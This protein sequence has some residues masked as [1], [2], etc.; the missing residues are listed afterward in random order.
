MS[1]DQNMATRENCRGSEA[2]CQTDN[3]EERCF[4][5]KKGH[6]GHQGHEGHHDRSILEAIVILRKKKQKKNWFIS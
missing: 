2:I 6:H 3:I 4:G 5:R 1:H